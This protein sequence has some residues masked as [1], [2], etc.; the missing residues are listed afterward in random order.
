MSDCDF[1][2]RCALA[3]SDL[4]AIYTSDSVK[5]CGNCDR[6]V[7]LTSTGAETALFSALRQC[8]AIAPSHEMFEKIGWVGECDLDWME[9]PAKSVRVKLRCG[10]GATGRQL[11]GFALLFQDLADYRLMLSHWMTGETVFLGEYA[12]DE[13]T[14]LLEQLRLWD[15]DPGQ[16]EVTPASTD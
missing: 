16:V 2:K 11:E 9:A 10:S 12:P 1:K 13:A 8:V 7:F 4:D 14:A 6:N 15:I 5:F 3:W